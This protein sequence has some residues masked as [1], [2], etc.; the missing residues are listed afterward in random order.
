ISAEKVY[1]G[2]NAKVTGTLRVEAPQKPE[3]AAT[4]V[5]GDLQYTKPQTE[6][7][8]A[9]PSVGSVIARRVSA[10]GY[11]LVANLAIAALLCLVL[12]RGCKIHDGQPSHS[13][14][15]LRLSRVIV[16]TLVPDFTLHH[17]YWF[18]HCRH[19]RPV[20]CGGG[21]DFHRLCRGFFGSAGSSEVEYLGSLPFRGWGSESGEDHSLHQRLGFLCRHDVYLWVAC[22]G[23]LASD[24]VSTGSP[25]M[26]GN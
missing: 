17:F 13:F 12:S 20:Y 26:M 23:G 15:G 11:W 3:I 21:D 9:K 16:F 1:L 6:T 2:P 18:A 4:A 10:T 7:A 14:V 24:E 19:P 5:V 8:T 25:G 22:P